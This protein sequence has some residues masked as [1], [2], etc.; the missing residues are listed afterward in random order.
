MTRS[1]RGRVGRSWVERHAPWISSGLSHIACYVMTRDRV[2][3]RR[4]DPGKNA[5]IGGL[6]MVIRY[7]MP[8]ASLSMRNSTELVVGF[9]HQTQSLVANPRHQCPIDGY[10]VPLEPF[11]IVD[12]R[13]FRT[14]ERAVRRRISGSQSHDQALR[15]LTGCPRNHNGP[16]L[17]R[18]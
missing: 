10:R 5:K 17:R 4:A 18:E 7:H 11:R 12:R 9:V 3:C 1:A 8:E 13:D 2:S 16:F 15:D 14:C 6:V